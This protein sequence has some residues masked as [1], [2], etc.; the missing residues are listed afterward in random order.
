[1][2]LAK[3]Y[4]DMF[5]FVKKNICGINSW[6]LFPDTMCCSKLEKK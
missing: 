4:N 1:M 5:E 2:L 6:L 3:N